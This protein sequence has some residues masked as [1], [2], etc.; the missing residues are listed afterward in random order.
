MKGCEKRIR[1]ILSKIG[2]IPT[3]WIGPPNWCEDN[4]YNK[5]LREVMGPRGYYPSN[6]LTFE[7]RKTA[8]IRL[9]LHLPCGWI[10][11]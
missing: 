2:N 8:G 7:R 6:K 1:A 3:I 4:G 5:L 11:L 9:W 10:R